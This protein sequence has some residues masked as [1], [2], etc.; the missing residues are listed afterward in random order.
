[1][2]DTQAS[3]LWPLALY[4]AAVIL[5]V[6]GLMLV[7]HFLG[8]GRKP[9]PA[10]APFES[11]I[12]GIGF[13]RFR[14]PVAFY[15]VALFF[16]VFDLEA[17]FLYAWAVALRQTGWPGFVEALV[18]ILILLAALVYVWRLGGLDWGPRRER[19]DAVRNQARR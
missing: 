15:L 19:A 8:A 3:A 4:G 2:V 14:V 1:M 10:D 12:V 17:A 9:A 16:V 6:A 7:S 5:L 18:F 13:G 11:G